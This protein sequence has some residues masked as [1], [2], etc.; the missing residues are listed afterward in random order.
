MGILLKLG[1]K[2]GKEYLKRN[3]KLLCCNDAIAV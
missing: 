3:I 2:R 1:E